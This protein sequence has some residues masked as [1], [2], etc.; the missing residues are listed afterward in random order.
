MRGCDSREQIRCERG[1]AALARQ[2][3][4]YKSDFA[5]FEM[6]FHE[7]WLKPATRGDA[8]G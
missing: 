8:P 4:T 5:N 1:N 2:M 3:I 6:V 7:A